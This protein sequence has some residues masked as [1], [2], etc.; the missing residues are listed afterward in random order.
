MPGEDRFDADAF[1][2]RT[3]DI[4]HQR[5]DLTIVSTVEEEITVKS[6]LHDGSGAVTPYVDSHKLAASELAFTAREALTGAMIVTHLHE[7][8]HSLTVKSL[9]LPPER[10]VC[11]DQ[12]LSSTPRASRC[13]GE[14]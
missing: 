10:S 3:F 7:R 2:Q 14:P 12:S 11:A 9:R 1:D 8:V 13:H 6:A 4:M 5:R